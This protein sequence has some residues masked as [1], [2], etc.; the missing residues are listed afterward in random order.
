MKTFFVTWFLTAPLLISAENDKLKTAAPSAPRPATT[1]SSPTP[2][3]LTGKGVTLFNGKNLEGW[4]KSEFGGE[5]EVE[6]TNS[7]IVVQMG[8]TMSGVTFTN[9]S[10]L[11]TNRYEISLEAM[12]LEG[13]DFFCAV[14]FPVGTNACSL[15]LGGWGGAIV[16]L[17]SIDDM[18]ASENESTQFMSFEKNRWYKIRLQITEEKIMAWVD[19]KKMIEQEIK[20]KKVSL[21]AGGI[22]ASL[23]FGLANY[24]TRSA[25]RNIQ[26]KRLP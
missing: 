16:G 4:K 23:P 24:Q 3:N 14:T 25:Y 5:G 6:M 11:P 10:V 22:E 9:P 8:A 18:D 21:R 13:N 2:T 19:E 20:G 17:S 26:I 15:I 1:A 7:T 12:K